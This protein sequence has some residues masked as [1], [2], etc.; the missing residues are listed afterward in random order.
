VQFFGCPD[1]FLNL[2]SQVSAGEIIALGLQGLSFASG[3]GVTQDFTRPALSLGGRAKS[4]FLSANPFTQRPGR[5]G[6][7]N[8]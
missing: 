2:I 5:I 7:T 8:R 6:S 1:D 4:K 3:Q